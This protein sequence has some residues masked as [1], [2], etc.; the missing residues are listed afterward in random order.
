MSGFRVGFAPITW[1]N[2]DLPAEL[3]PPVDYRRVL[4]E[5]AAA[6]YTAT[7]LG[8]GFPRELLVQPPEA[9]LAY[10]AAKVV[11]H[12]RLTAFTRPQDLEPPEYGALIYAHYCDC[13]RRRLCLDS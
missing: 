1:N 2:E 7:E 10:F 6:G 3:A 11:G 8:D 4:D 5:V 12:P 9:R 13:V